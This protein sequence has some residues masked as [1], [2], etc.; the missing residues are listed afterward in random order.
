M[1]LTDYFKKAPESAGP[2]G[3]VM[4]KKAEQELIAY[5]NKSFSICKQNRLQF[6]RIWYM[7]MAFYFGKQYAEW[8]YSVLDSSNLQTEQSFSRLRTPPAPRWR[9]RL[10]C[11]KVRPLIRKEVAKI[12]K[13]KPRGFVIPASTDEN[14]RL[15]AKAAEAI[16]E[17]IWRD[18]HMNRVIR[19]S[20]LWLALCGSSFIKDWYERDEVDVYGVKGAIKSEPV[21]P[22]HFFVPDLQ[23]EELE[24]QPFV[25]HGMAKDPDWVEKSFNV[26]V[27]PDSGAGS[28]ILEQRF[29]SALGVGQ[30]NSEKKY[31]SVKEAWYKPNKRF[32]DGALII[33]ANEKILHF[34]EGWPYAHKEYPFSKIDHI[35]TGRFYGDSTIVDLIPL[36]KEYNKG[37]SQVLESRNRMSKPQLAAVRGSIEVNK[38]T[39]EPGL[40]VLVKP[41]YQF[42]TP[43]PLQ[44]LP[45]YVMDAIDRAEADMQDVASAHEISKGSV[46][47]GVTA[48]CLRSEARALTKLGWKN[49]ES[50]KVGEEILAYVPER[51]ILEW[52]RVNAVY[53]TPFEGQLHV[54]ESESISARSTVDH[55]WWTLNRYQWDKGNNVGG[56]VLSENLTNNHLIPLPGY[57][58]LVK[59]DSSSVLSEDFCELLGWY[60]TD[61]CMSTANKTGISISQS[62]DAKPKHYEELKDLIE[63]NGW[64]Y[65]EDQQPGAKGF[66][67]NRIYLG[68]EIGRQARSIA[69]GK[70]KLL[71]FDFISSLSKGQLQALKRGLLL[72][73][74]S[75]EL[76]SSG[77]RRYKLGT[78]S[79][80]HAYRFQMICTLL[81]YTTNMKDYSSTQGHKY[82]S[83]KW[84]EVQIKNAR[85][86][87]V[88][89]V[90]H[91][92]KGLEDYVGTVWCPSV[93]S[94]YWLAR[95]NGKVYITGNTAISF[96]QEQ[97]DSSLHTT[98]SSLEE[99]VERV[100]RHFLSNAN[101]FWT[102]ERKVRVIGEN[103]R[104]ESYQ[105]S[106]ANIRGNIDFKI[107][108]GSATPTSRAAK[109]AFI[110][111]LGKMGWIP[112]DRALRY[113]DMAETGRLYEEMQLNPRQAQRENLKMYAG[114]DVLTNNYDDDMI[115]LQEHE[116]YRK[117]EEYENS[118]D[119]CK[120]R[121][122]THC[123]MHKQ[124]LALMQGLMLAPGDPKLDALARGLPVGMPMG[125]EQNGQQPQ[126]PPASPQGGVSQG[127]GAV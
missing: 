101:Q 118:D 90:K 69:V 10:I 82:K 40:C 100:S 121:F 19:R 55:K 65:R 38:I 61:G 34:K 1:T 66:W 80:A 111:E 58:T 43:I 7:N 102:A 32:K 37:R 78:S 81:G 12:I 97:D 44:N 87:T 63:R 3:E 122:E 29:L 35:P 108:A 113:L 105:F 92:N 83:K 17:A 6:E 49:H 85:Y 46:P 76:S 74:G 2:V 45:S 50:L 51:N 84:F 93:K 25:I 117:T 33:W 13:E 103:G 127:Q 120:T 125:A 94:G 28:G 62:E 68:G 21:T 54:L 31:V 20:A 106:K 52:Q 22:F 126:Q 115:H 26:R 42:P 95:D 27:Q 96:L 30:I 107:E 124:H 11:N 60:I 72:G 109:Q 91:S 14:D 104:F 23:E 86:G 88:A 24:S 41:G 73:D 119:A 77:E 56:K 114:E 36:Q 79:S 48:A 15:G 110:T 116:N 75:F 53:S 5:C 16:Y 98:T 57:A 59:L 70:K 4:S 67:C 8:S 18:L 47:T 39:S 123:G 89:S 99:A 64:I 112:P 71:G 9:V